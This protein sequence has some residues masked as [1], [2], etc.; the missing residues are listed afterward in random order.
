MPPTGGQPYFMVLDPGTDEWRAGQLGGD[1][2]GSFDNLQVSSLLGR[3][4][5]GMPPTGGQPYFMVLDPGTDEWR[6]GQLGGDIS[7]SFDNLQVNILG[8][9]IGGMPPT[10][11]QAF[12]LVY[13]DSKEMWMAAPLQGEVGGNWN[14]LEIKLPLEK[15]ADL[16]SSMIQ[17]EN[18]SG[19]G[20]VAT[21]RESHGLRGT[22][23]IQ[24]GSLT[25]PDDL[26]PETL[27]S[28]VLGEGVASG[29]NNGVGIWGR[30]VTA[31]NG[32]GIGGI[33]EGGAVG[34]LAITRQSNGIGFWA[35]GS[36]NGQTALRATARGADLAGFFEGDVSISDDLEVAD[37]FNAGSKNFKIDH[38]LAPRDKYLYHST[39]ESPERKTLYDGIVTTDADG[40]ATVQLPPYFEALNKDYRY[41]LTV[42]G[43]FAQA[44]IAE[45]IQNNQFLIQTDQP[46]IEVSW[47][48]TG[49]RN[50]A[51]ARNNPLEVEV[52]KEK[53]KRGTYLHPKAF[54]ILA[55]MQT[56]SELQDGKLPINI[57]ASGSSNK[58]NQ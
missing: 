1:V 42:I 17:L 11:G 20:I 2:T 18:D 48:V 5:G 7:G 55:T 26:D 27:A 15:S 10:G 52:E 37:E 57:E 54:G 16:S 30:A 51:Y 21:S 47:Q 49:I 3:P 4:I 35:L 9:P 19:P 33:L 40:Y 39:V 53:E 8:R 6:A 14:S 25:V 28:G 23:A 38:P 29:S 56:P 50:D 43:S 22:S 46:G 36:N 41:H 12:S 58:Q 13:D 32:S 44:I 24:N 31:S 45:K 34:G